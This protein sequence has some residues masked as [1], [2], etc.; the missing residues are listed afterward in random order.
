LPILYGDVCD[1]EELVLSSP[2]GVLDIGRLLSRGGVILPWDMLPA[3]DSGGVPAVTDLSGIE[4]FASLRVLDCRNHH[5]TSLDV[6]ANTRLEALVCESNRL[7][8][9]DVSRNLALRQ[10]WCRHNKLVALDLSKNVSLVEVNCGW[11]DLRSLRLPR[12]GSLRSVACGWN[13]LPRLDV[14]RC[15]GL[16]K[17]VCC[18]NCFASE[19]AV[20][21]VAGLR[22]R[23]GEFEFGTQKAPVEAPIRLRSLLAWWSVLALIIAAVGAV[24]ALLGRWLGI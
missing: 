10:L 16:A 1:C 20:V 5:L 17:L 12:G 22:D 3:G 21:G 4:N 24:C 9:L 2:S 6:S 23:G 13:A 11:N 18:A 15:A 8:S 14:S 7:T 19:S